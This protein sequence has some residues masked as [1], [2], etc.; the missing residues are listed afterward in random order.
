MFFFIPT[1][2][3]TFLC[4]FGPI[5]VLY[6]HR[7]LSSAVILMSFIKSWFLVSPQQYAQLQE[8]YHSYIRS[9]MRVFLWV[10][11][12]R[13]LCICCWNYN[14]TYLLRRHWLY[15]C[16][17][18]ITQRVKKSHCIWGVIYQAKLNYIKLTKI[19]SKFSSY[20]ATFCYPSFLEFE[21]W[22]KLTRHETTCA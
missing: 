2:F 14:N 18:K 15:D 5:N 21:S 11:R 17:R 9:C 4:F 6:S 12:G 1:T 20:D 8:F 16:Y 7:S 13:K 10:C 19:S 22:K 3:F